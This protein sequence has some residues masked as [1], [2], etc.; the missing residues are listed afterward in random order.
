MSSRWRNSLASLDSCVP[1]SRPDEH[2]S[3][4]PR[5]HLNLARIRFRTC[6]PARSP[7]R[8]S[9]RRHL[10]GKRNKFLS[11]PRSVHSFLADYSRRSSLLPR[12]LPQIFF[13][14]H[15]VL[16]FSFFIQGEEELEE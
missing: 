7:A 10:D 4:I 15:F 14:Y 2:R 6:C 5:N 16:G 3:G 9:P 1:A 8:P 11:S 12:V 13:Y